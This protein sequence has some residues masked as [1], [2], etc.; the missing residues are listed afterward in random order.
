M[1]FEVHRFSHLPIQEQLLMEEDLLRHKKGNYILLNTEAPP[2]IVLGI[3][4]K[5]DELI[6]LEHLPPSI[7]LVR[8]FSGGGTVIIDEETVFVTF[9][10]NKS[11]HSFA[12]Y[13]EP[14]LRFAASMLQKATP[15]L[16]LRENDFVIHDRKCGGNAL[17]IKKDRWLVHTSFLWNYTQ[18]RMSLLKHPSKTPPYRAGRSHDEF[19]CKLADLLPCKKRWIDDLEASFLPDQKLPEVNDVGK[20][21]RFHDR[22]TD[23]IHMDKKRAD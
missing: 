9:I 14:I 4:N 23:S 19:L 5:A 18:E 2:A 16:I 20:K 13:P 15:N 21:F 12:P 8:R 10:C 1:T 7:P 22:V 6:H 17:Y 11:L 3:S